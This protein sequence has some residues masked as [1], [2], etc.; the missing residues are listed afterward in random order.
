M[1]LPF[2][3]P[4][5]PPSVMDD[6]QLH[7]HSPTPTVLWPSFYT[8]PLEGGTGDT[9]PFS[10]STSPLLDY[11]PHAVLVALSEKLIII[12]DGLRPDC[13][14]YSSEVHGVIVDR[15]MRSL[16]HPATH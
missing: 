9:V 10:S 5:G 13:M 6:L 11:C 15:L 16:C 1:S 3:L 4:S 2:Q 14:Q 12:R 8:S 7:L